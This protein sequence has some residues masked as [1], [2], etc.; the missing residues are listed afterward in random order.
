MGA[1]PEREAPAEEFVSANFTVERGKVSCL[2]PFFL[3]G[4]KVSV[5]SRVVYATWLDEERSCRFF[6][7]TVFFVLNPLL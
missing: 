3:R 2:S 4:T 7:V 1:W 5:N 6:P